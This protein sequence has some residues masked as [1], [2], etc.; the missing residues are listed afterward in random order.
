MRRRGLGVIGMGEQL[1]VEPWSGRLTEAANRRQDPGEAEGS[2]GET[3]SDREYQIY[4]GEH[5]KTL[6]VDICC[7]LMFAR[8]S[9][10][11]NAYKRV[12]N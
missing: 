2:K 8:V 12:A 4:G 7:Y 1:A 11:G 6:A 5:T 9:I 3:A 10:G